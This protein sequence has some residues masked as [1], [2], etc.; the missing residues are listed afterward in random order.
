MKWS[1]VL[2]FFIFSIFGHGHHFVISEIFANGP[3]RTS[4]QG[5]EWLE[6]TNLFKPI[7][8]NHLA[9]DIYSGK[10]GELT[11]SREIDLPKPIQFTDSLLIAKINLLAYLNV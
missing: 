8:I 5:K 10:S 2:L 3:G 4:D 11:F 1:F 9:M 7:E 6:I